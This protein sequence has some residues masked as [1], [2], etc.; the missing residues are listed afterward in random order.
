ME[1]LIENFSPEMKRIDYFSHAMLAVGYSDESKAFIVRNS[2]GE[3]WVRRKAQLDLK[4]RL[5]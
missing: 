1:G 3:D 4:K 2:W 5:F